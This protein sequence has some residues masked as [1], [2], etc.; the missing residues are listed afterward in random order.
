MNGYEMDDDERAEYEAYLDDQREHFEYITREYLVACFTCGFA[1]IGTEPALVEAG[2]LLAKE[3]LCPKHHEAERMASSQKAFENRLRT[4]GNN[5][6]R[7]VREW[8]LPIVRAQAEK[9]LHND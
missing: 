4:N 2:W 7:S 1:D 9:A 6:L 8:N 3:T 5:P